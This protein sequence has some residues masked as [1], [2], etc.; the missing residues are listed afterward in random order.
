MKYQNNQN[1]FTINHLLIFVM[2]LLVACQVYVSNRIA[3]SG[4]SISMYEQKALQIEDD[5]RKLLSEN[6][7]NYSLTTLSQRAQELGFVEPMLILHLEQ[8]TSNLALNQ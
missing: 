3:T 5:N 2:A 8:G 4:K 6:V 1:R 7:K